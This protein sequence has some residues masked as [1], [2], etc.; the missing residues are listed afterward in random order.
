MAAGTQ[1]S[2]NATDSIAGIAVDRLAAKATDR[3]AISAIHAHATG[4]KIETKA[5]VAP[6]LNGGQ[7]S[8]EPAIADTYPATGNATKA[9]GT[10]A[11]RL[12]LHPPFR[13]I[14]P[15]VPRE[16]VRKARITGRAGNPP[17]ATIATSSGTTY[18]IVRLTS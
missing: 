14:I 4:S 9:A 13:R 5:A 16:D 6:A 18:G 7:P 3:V 2:I 1:N 12:S 15:C 11:H 8:G 10:A 17:M